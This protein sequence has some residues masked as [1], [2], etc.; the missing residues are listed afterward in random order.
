MSAGIGHNRGPALGRNGW[1]VHCWTRA[2]AELFP[3]LPLEVVRARVRRAKEIGLDYRTYAGIRATTGHD[4][5]AFLYS[6]N[7]LRM[8]RDGEAEA[9][10]VAKL[11]AAQGISHHL[12][13]A[14]RLDADRARAMLSAQGLSPERIAEMPLL[15]MSPSRQRAL[16]DALRV[17]TDLTRIPADRIL[18]IAETEL[19]HEWAATGRMAGTLAAERFFAQAAG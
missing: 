18:I 1:A 15:G 8:L 12:A 10:R 4:L 16:L 13:L 9:G 17:R 5:V 7:T 2:R 6:S 3:T 14:P 19:E 11:A